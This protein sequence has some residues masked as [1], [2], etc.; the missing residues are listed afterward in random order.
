VPKLPGVR[1]PLS[2]AVGE[3]VVAWLK[4]PIKSELPSTSTPTAPGEPGPGGIEDP[5]PELDPLP[6]PPEKEPSLPRPRQPQPR[7]PAYPSQ[8]DKYQN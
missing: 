7:Q 8:D 3:Q 4:S 2:K 5:N 1:L 6:L